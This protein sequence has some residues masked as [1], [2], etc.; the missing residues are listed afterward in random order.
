MAEG[1][2]QGRI[3]LA[4]GGNW[5]PPAYEG[6]TGVYP[7]SKVSKVY[8]TKRAISPERPTYGTKNPHLDSS[9]YIFTIFMLIYI[10]TILYIFDIL[11]Y[12]DILKLDLPQIDRNLSPEHRFDHEL[13]TGYQGIRQKPGNAASSSY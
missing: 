3:A 4:S 13:S 6:F 10:F 2:T 1:T 5:S 9:I 8:S 7:P 12:K 11:Y